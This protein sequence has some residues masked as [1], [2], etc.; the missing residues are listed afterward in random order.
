MR[1]LNRSRANPLWRSSAVSALLLV[2]LSGC[3]TLES[4]ARTGRADAI[5]VDPDPAAAS[6][7]VPPTSEARVRF[8]QAVEAMEQVRFD[9]ARAVF[10]D[11]ASTYPQLSGP[12]T[13]LG[14]L[15]AQVD[16]EPAAALGHFQAA[17]AADPENAVAH[18]WMGVLLRKQG[19]YAKAEQH[20]LSALQARPDYPFA[21]RNLAMLY[22]LYLDRPAEARQHYDAYRQLAEGSDA[23]MAEVWLRALQAV[24]FGPPAVA[25]MDAGP[26]P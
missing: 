19:A 22:E 18:N 24:P 14:I 1:G 6:D 13:N 11:L 8:D 20:Y 7:P 26:Q 25:A 12:H 10:E 5:T 15:A 2:A 23:L 16:D 9:E 21:H 4:N 17:V 3:S